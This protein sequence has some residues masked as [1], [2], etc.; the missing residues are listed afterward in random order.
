MTI[1]EVLSK[2]FY[3]ILIAIYLIPIITLPLLPRIWPH[4]N[5]AQRC[6]V[7][8]IE[9]WWICSS[10]IFIL[11]AN[12]TTTVSSVRGLMKAMTDSGVEGVPTGRQRALNLGPV[13]EL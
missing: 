3:T 1:S 6:M 7:C 11:A 4:F 12:K 5:R 10:V 2:S 13:G 9:I 8:F